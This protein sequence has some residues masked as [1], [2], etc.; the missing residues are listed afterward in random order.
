MNLKK[1]KCK[2]K[3]NDYDINTI[4]HFNILVEPEDTFEIELESLKKYFEIYV[5]IDEINQIEN[6]EH[7]NNQMIN[8][9][10]DKNLKKINKVIIVLSKFIQSI[11]EYF[12]LIFE[13]RGLECVIVY[14]LSIG[15]CLEST[16]DQMYLIVYLD[17]DHLALPSRYIYYQVEQ[18][19]SKFLTDVELLKKTIYIMEKAEQVWEYSSVTRP[20]YSKYCVNKLKWSPMPY[21][22]VPNKLQMNLDWDLCEYDIFFFGNPNKRRKKILKILSEH[23]RVKIGFGYYGNKKIKYIGKSKIILNL[24]YYKDA[25]LETCRI[26]EILN[27]NKLIISEKSPLDV[28]NME[29]YSGHVIFVDEID[30]GITNIKQMIKTIK[31][32]LNFSNY[33]DKI[34]VDKKKLSEKINDLICFLNV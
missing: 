19:N 22:Y 11:G 29:L 25:G 10:P 4:I 23:F 14:S 24:H 18:A 12:R 5:K 21:Y 32:Y 6:I 3:N 15:D 31:Y 33:L 34:N 20:I 1:V 17:N 28:T 2:F 9:N 8:L 27:H 16:P 30:D 13:Y 26:N 7:Q